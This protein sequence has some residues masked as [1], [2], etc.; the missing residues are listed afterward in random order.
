[1][2]YYPS[3]KYFSTL[4]FL[5]LSLSN[6]LYA[7]NPPQGDGG[8]F[9]NG[10]V[11]LVPLSSCPDGEWHLQGS[12][13][14]C[15]AK[16]SVAT[17]MNIASIECPIGKA[18][19]QGSDANCSLDRNTVTL[20]DSSAS[21]EENLSVG[22]VVGFVDIAHLGD[23]SDI[24]SF[25][26]SDDEFFEVNSSGVIKLKKALDYETTNEYNLTVVVTNGAGISTRV[27]LDIEV[28][29][30]LLAPKLVEPTHITEFTY[31]GDTNW[32][33]DNT[34]YYSPTGSW[35]N[36]D[37]GDSQSACMEASVDVTT[38]PYQLIYQYKV[39]TNEYGDYLRFY[40]DNSQQSYKYNTDWISSPLYELTSGSH[41][42][43]WCYTKDS[44]TSYGSD[45]AWVDDIV[46][47]QMNYTLAEDTALGQLGN[48]DIDPHYIEPIDSFTIAGEGNEHFEVAT[49]GTLSLVS[50]LDYE[51]QRDY[52]LSI[53]AHNSAGA[54]NTVTRTITVTDVD[55]LYITNAFY[56]DNGTVGDT[57]DDRLLL[58]YSKTLDEP[59][60]ADP[61]AD[62]YIINES[63]TIDSSASS[64]AEYNSSKTYY[65]HSI[66]LVDPNDI[67]EQNISIADATLTANSEATED[68]TKTLIRAVI[69]SSVVKKTGQTKSYDESG[70]KAVP[71]SSIRD[72]GYYQ[73]GV[74]PRYSRDDENETVTDHITGLMWADD[75]Y[76]SSVTKQWVTQ[77]NYDAGN[78]DDTSGDTATTYCGELTLGGF[79]DWRLPSRKE[80]VGLSDYGRVN[81]AINPIFNNIASYNYWSSTT[82]AGRSSYAWYVHFHYGNQ[83]YYYKSRSYFVRCVRAGQL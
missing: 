14:V 19:I 21:T 66:S 43:K 63:E 10:T 45:T 22:S 76:V 36:E 40:I 20:G 27:K 30:V 34:T 50:K 56:D 35:K 24:V 47:G 29:D 49:D 18:Y 25:S 7:D 48:I 42:L 15:V 16:E 65:P 2:P 9:E 52:T 83:S 78:Y 70:D 44:S 31:S 28:E 67:I 12:D 1:M 74:A 51:T 62:N 68:S 75:A 6:L 64:T 8:A 5:L 77:A 59:S 33:E 54:S 17:T 41:T 23:G 46:A 53:T 81:P 38:T 13:D 82:Y 58:Q 55:D 80:L 69:G 61:I 57:T 32:T 79:S 4:V 11:V 72:D 39:D 37:I 60:I 3:I 26:L 71:I 73:S